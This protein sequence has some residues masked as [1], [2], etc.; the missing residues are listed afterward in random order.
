[1]S[2][3][4]LI[5]R[6]MYFPNTYVWLLLFSAMDIMLTWVIL[7]FGG[8]EVNPIA[9]WVI[10]GF[11]LNG[12]IVYKFALILV[13]IGICEAVAALR[14]PTASVLSK[15]SVLIALVPVVWSLILLSRFSG[16]IG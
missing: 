13:F 2:V 7:Y 8:S 4:G 11:G 6:Q 10:D 16:L 15:I 12:M 9:R 5:Q 3:I 14:K 1:M